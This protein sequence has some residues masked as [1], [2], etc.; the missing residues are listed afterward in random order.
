M[1][2]ASVWGLSCSHL[3]SPCGSAWS[4]KDCISGFYEPSGDLNSRP[5]LV[6]QMLVLTESSFHQLNIHNLLKHT[7]LLALW[8]GLSD[9]GLP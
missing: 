3:P 1:R 2:S 6:Q 5:Q 9:S 8:A 4:I 7:V